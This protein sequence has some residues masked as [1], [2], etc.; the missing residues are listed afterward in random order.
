MIMFLSKQ[1]LPFPGHRDDFNSR[2]QSNVLAI[3]KLIAKCNPVI[4]KDYLSNTQ[5][6]KKGMATCLFQIIKNE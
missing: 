5:L 6:S 2:N 4:N 3:L 1:N